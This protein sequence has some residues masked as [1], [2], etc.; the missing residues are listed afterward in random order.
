MKECLMFNQNASKRYI[1]S[2]KLEDMLKIAL[3]GLDENFDNI[4]EKATLLWKK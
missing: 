4:I 2:K 3:D 1:G